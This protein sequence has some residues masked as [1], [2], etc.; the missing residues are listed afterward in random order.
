V[1][2]CDDGNA[3]KKTCRFIFFLKYVFQ[4]IIVLMALS[5]YVGDSPNRAIKHLVIQ[6]WNII[7]YFLYYSTSLPCVPP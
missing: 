4:L 1:P 6:A 2:F 3:R 5:F 7:Y